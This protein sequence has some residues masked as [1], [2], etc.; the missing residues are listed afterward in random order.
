MGQWKN[1]AGNYG[2]SA[3][4][5]HTP[6][7]VEDVQ[8]LAARSGTLKALGTRHSFNDI[9]DTDDN[10]VS[11]ASLNRVVE[12]DRT[13]ST[14]TVEGGI[15]Y[16]ELGVYLHGQGLAVPNM[17]SLPHISVAGACATATHGSGDRNGSLA[18]AVRAMDIVTASGELVRLS[19]DADAGLMDAAAV[20][21]G[22]LGIVVRLTLDVVPSFQVRQDVYDR[23]PLAALDAHLGDIFSAAYSVSLFTDWREPVFNLLWLKSIAADGGADLKELP[24]DMYGAVRSGGPRH[25]VPG[26][27]ADHC[28]AQLGAAGAWHERLPHFRLEFTPSNGQELQSEYIVPREHAVRALAAVN[29]MRERIAPLLHICEVRSIAADRQWMSPY[30]ERE[31][32]GIHFTWKDNWPAV[33]L[34]LPE[35][36]ERLAP[37]HAR[38]HW[39]KLFA[40]PGRQVL[41]LYEKADD[42]RQLMRRFDPNGKFRNAYLDRIFGEK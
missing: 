2:Y 36:E 5:L 24:A 26:M 35:I 37:F 25:P 41:E 23:L 8:E 40:M 38:P 13:R 14:V 34:V 28:T 18:A 31:S 12:L 4:N 11:L 10:L 1:W 29:E 27:S 22:A 19:R 39:G 7:S 21:L 30:Y 6:G 9:A 20:H 42:F 15:R 17:A 33:R 3:S 32:I 16:G